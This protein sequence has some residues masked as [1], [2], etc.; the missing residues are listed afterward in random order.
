M[1]VKIY[2]QGLAL[3]KKLQSHAEEKLR[4]ELG[5]FTRKI[6]RVDVFL[7]DVNGP[8][9]GEDMVCKVKISAFGTTPIVVQEKSVN[10]YE[11]ISVCS[12]RVKRTV[13]RKFDRVTRRR[14][15]NPGRLELSDTAI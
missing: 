8:K 1:L 6:R 15:I 13:A 10:I 9:G 2:T 11:A 5:A 12:H 7:S 14:K 4:L 3:S